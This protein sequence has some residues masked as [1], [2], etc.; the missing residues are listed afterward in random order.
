[1]QRD[2]AH[3]TA[4]ECMFMQIT[5]KQGHYLMLRAALQRLR[6]TVCQQTWADQRA[7]EIR[8]WI[9]NVAEGSCPVL[10]PT[11]R[12]TFI[13][14]WK[15]PLTPLASISIHTR[16]FQPYLLSK[17]QHGD[18]TSMTR[19]LINGPNKCD[20]CQRHEQLETGSMVGRVGRGARGREAL[21]YEPKRERKRRQ[22]VCLKLLF[23]G[24]CNL[25]RPSGLKQKMSAL[26][27][28][29]QWSF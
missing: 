2:V 26:L 4:A 1:M 16:T 7:N 5:N 21:Q 24:F 10:Y 15:E 20:E 8:V 14:R 9:N 3:R 25:R 13:H 29:S 28:L 11:T 19:W 17:L 27:L 22:R 12:L 23:M 6:Y 18:H